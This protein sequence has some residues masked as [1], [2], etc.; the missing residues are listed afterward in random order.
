T[1]LCITPRPE[2]Y[3]APSV[4]NDIPYSETDLAWYYAITKEAYLQGFI[5]GYLGE[6]DAGGMTPFKPDISISRAEGTKIILEVLES[7][8]VIDMG[9]VVI[10]TDAP[11]YVPYMQ[12]AQD[13]TDYLI[14]D[15]TLGEGKPFIITSDEA[16]RATEALTRYEFMKMAV[17]VLDFYNCYADQDSDGDGLSDYEEVNVYGSDPYDADTDKGGIFDG[18][19]VAVGTDPMDRNDDDSDGD[20]LVNADEIDLYDTDPF[21]PD[22]DDGGTYDGV[23]VLQGTNPTD[24]PSDDAG[25]TDQPIEETLLEEE[26]VLDGLEPGITVVTYEC[27]TCPCPTSI[28]NMADLDEGDSLYSAIMNADKTEVLSISPSVKIEEILGHGINKHV[29]NPSLHEKIL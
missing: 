10:P 3:L 5:V 21:D 27:M 18:E 17:R 20:S 1:I 22:T 4:F 28:E 29:S 2:A 16:S 25:V 15:T 14:S 19:E 9:D 12:M 7:L 24:D 13:L 8:G 23:E 11:W 26:N 6:K